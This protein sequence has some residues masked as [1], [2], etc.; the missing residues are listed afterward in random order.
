M[1]G[2]PAF[3]AKGGRSICLPWRQEAMGSR[4]ARMGR[5]G[6]HAPRALHP[7]HAGE[8]CRDFHD[9]AGM[10]N[11][12]PCAPEPYP[13]HGSK[14]LCVARGAAMLERVAIAG[15]AA[16]ASWLKRGH[17]G[18][19]V[20]RFWG[21]PPPDAFDDDALARLAAF[22]LG[23][24]EGQRHRRRHQL[25]GGFRIKMTAGETILYRRVGGFEFGFEKD[26]GARERVESYR[27]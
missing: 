25:A 20:L 13:C 24:R 12:P 8:N 16:A 14:G 5:A 11:R 21:Y 1:V 6:I 17:G 23:E 22:E 2:R 7:P 15:L 4:A 18:S 9:I 26:R 19:F 10:A 27:P 3:E